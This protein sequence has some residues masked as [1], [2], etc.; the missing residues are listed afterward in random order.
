MEWYVARDAQNFG[1]FSF[2][3][4]LASARDGRLTKQ[5]QLW[6]TGMPQWV[7]AASVPGIW[8]PPPTT[9]GEIAAS[10]DVPILHD[11]TPEKDPQSSEKSAV[12]EAEKQ[13]FITRYWRGDISLPASYWLVGI[14]TSIAITALSNAFGEFVPALQ[15]TPQQCGTAF[16]GF[17]VILVALLIWQSVGLWRSAGKYIKSSKT[18]G[19]GWAARTLLTIAVVRAGVDFNQLVR[20]MLAESARLAVGVDDVPASQMRLMNN[21][22]ELEISGGIPF[23]TADAFQKLLDAAPS[24]R[25]VHLNS[26]GGRIDEGYKIGEIIRHKGL[27]TYTSSYCMSA[28]TI[29]FLGGNLRLLGEE[30]RLG[31]HSGS[32][33]GLD[34]Q[35]LPD[36]NDRMR[37][38]FADMR[39]PAW[40]SNKA[41][42]TTAD[43][44]WYPT[45]DELV[46]ANVVSQIVDP[47]L[48]AMS[49]IRD[50]Q[51]VSGAE[52]TLLK[53]P[54]YAALKSYDPTTFN[55]ILAKI[56]DSIKNGKTAF[57]MQNE[58]HAIF[59]TQILPKYLRTSP[60][61]PLI[62]YWSSQI[63]DLRALARTRPQYCVQFLFPSER[64]P[65][66][67]LTRLMPQDVQK[68]DLDKLARL[69]EG[70][71][72]GP[73]AKVA[74]Q[75][76]LTP[77]VVSI[78]KAHPDVGPF[79]S[80]PERHYGE[81]DKLCGAFL[82]FY[83]E[84]LALP[85]TQAGPILRSMAQ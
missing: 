5:D 77:I 43:S 64:D 14:G 3:D 34:Q 80:E 84:I 55:V 22:S 21:A 13:N 83:E 7:P 56:S 70:A 20:P 74:T 50:W 29:A 40:F 18:P 49:G 28:C 82:A 31:F 66:F 17:L 1:P 78:A 12:S 85:P 41:F 60:D 44:M 72:K 15:L 30:A 2:E 42:A 57:Q 27:A 65:N 62:D 79:L 73:V 16:I 75:A 47:K 39:I 68:R 76:E 8:T 52:N 67:D 19:W 54:A 59:E 51:N 71:S 9:G 24:V 81:P 10:V 6:S 26:L 33:G 69:I 23:G 61:G 11:G 48:F 63:D 58:I 37:K 32:F 36:I 35:S 38:T 45:N 4:L 25:L 53:L 46:S